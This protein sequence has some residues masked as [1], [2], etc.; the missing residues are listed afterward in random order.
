MHEE[1]LMRSLLRQVHDLAQQH[2]AVGIEEIEV[3]AGP[4]SGIEPLLLQSAFERL[5]ESTTLCRT[6]TLSIQEVSLDVQ[7]LRCHAQ[8]VLQ[9]FRFVCTAC[10]STSL[11]ILRGDSLRLL[12]VRMQIHEDA[13]V[14]N[15]K[16][17]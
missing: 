2:H 1:S 13:E 9:D 10:G 14:I 5:K 16:S 15:R 12:N 4:L 6:A 7:C 8:S 17:E 11:K 3:E